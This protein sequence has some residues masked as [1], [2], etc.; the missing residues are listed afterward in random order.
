M[1]KAELVDAV[2]QKTGLSKTDVDLVIKATI[3]T[4]T[5][6]V[7]ANDKVS[8]IGFGSFELTTRAGRKAQI[9]GTNTIVDVLPS[10]SVKFKVGKQFKD[11]VNQK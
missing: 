1:K 3:Q 11:A 10:K 6:A 5:D 4:I 8:F 2:A 7:S 9:P